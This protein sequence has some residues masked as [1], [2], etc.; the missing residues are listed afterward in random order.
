[1]MSEWWARLFCRFG[2]SLK[3]MRIQVSVITF[4]TLHPLLRKTCPPSVWTLPPSAGE[5]WQIP[6]QPP[7]KPPPQP[8]RPLPDQLFALPQLQDFDKLGFRL[9]DNNRSPKRKQRCTH[10]RLS[11]R[12][13]VS[14]RPGNCLC[15]QH[16]DNDE[17][18]HRQS[19]S[20]PMN[21][22]RHRHR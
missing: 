8:P 3:S 11:A 15:Q 5:T 2:V 19:P 13:G 16:G 10:L 14:V 21:A 7:D 9:C 20:H 17:S 22:R 1:M 18:R 4:T 12:W 6:L